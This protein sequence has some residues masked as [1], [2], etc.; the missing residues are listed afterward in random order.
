[1]K[2]KPDSAHIRKSARQ[3]A[4]FPKEIHYDFVLFAECESLFMSRIN[5]NGEIQ[6]GPYPLTV[7]APDFLYLTA[8]EVS[9]D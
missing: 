7:H 8:D 9:P 5:N 6:S 1:M 3:G 2:E 4:A